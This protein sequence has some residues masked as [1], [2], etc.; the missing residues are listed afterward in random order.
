MA[1]VCELGLIPG[2]LL[3]RLPAGASFP[4]GDGATCVIQAHPAW[5]TVVTSM[6]LHGGWLHLIGNMWFLW[7]FGNNVEDSMGHARFLIFYLLC[8]L[9]AAALQIVLAARFRDP[10][11]RRLGRDRRR[12]GGLRRAVSE[13]PHP[14][15]GDLRVHR[16]HDRRARE[17]SCWDTGSCCSCSGAR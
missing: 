10:D 14:H 17:S 12:D 15:A 6:F 4:L 2:E 13:G 1:S 9:A 16:A 3:Q 8:G 5:Y 11:G 7:I